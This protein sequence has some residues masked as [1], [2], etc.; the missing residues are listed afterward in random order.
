MAACKTKEE[1]KLI[2]A[3]SLVWG[4]FRVFLQSLLK[5]ASSVLY[6]LHPSLDKDSTLLSP[7]GL[8]LEEELTTLHVF[9]THQQAIGYVA[10]N[11]S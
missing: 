6:L 7:Q 3:T 9:Q 10:L 5:L 11:F 4:Q 8:F 1:C 2:F